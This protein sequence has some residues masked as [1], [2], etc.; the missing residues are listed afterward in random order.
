[1]SLDE[2]VAALLSG[3]SSA[4]LGKLEL[5]GAPPRFAPGI[6]MAKCIV[7]GAL[8]NCSEGPIWFR[9]L[10]LSLLMCL[11]LSESSSSPRTEGLLLLLRGP[12]GV[13]E[14]TRCCEHKFD[15][16]IE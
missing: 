12:P 14:V 8:P 9:S 1:M 4:G 11:V 15:Q 10:E 6:A 16:L 3:I 2:E 7:P 13:M 5:G